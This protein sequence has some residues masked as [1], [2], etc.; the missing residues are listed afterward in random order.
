MPPRPFFSIIT[1]VYNRAPVVGR[2]LRSCLSQ[3]FASFE[4]VVVDDGSRDESVAAVRAFDDPRVRLIVHER[5]RGV[6]PAR[7]TA[8]AN[9][10]GE[11]LVFLDSDDELLP[12]ALEAIHRC[13]IAAAPDVGG[14]RFMCMDERGTSPVPAHHGQIFDYEAYLRWCD[15]A[16]AGGR[17]ETLPCARAST[18]PAVQYPDS[19]ALE[20]WYHLELARTTKVQACAD[21]VRRYHHDVPDRLTVPVAETRLRYAADEAADLDRI[22]TVHGEALRRF[23]PMLYRMTLSRA[24]AAHFLAGSRRGGI[25]R[26]MSA[27]RFMPFSP[28]LYAILFLGLL[29]AR[30]VA[31]IQALRGRLT[32]AGRPSR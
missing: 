13:A 24:A 22:L 28:R 11:W 26:T 9:A 19:H 7:N 21:V 23:A 14:L 18:F 29:G 30:P 15:A 12:G 2:A 3:S 20:Q 6:C 8:M 10:R 5:N 25:R 16:I 4:V 17:Q 32:G 1:P 27:W 31:K